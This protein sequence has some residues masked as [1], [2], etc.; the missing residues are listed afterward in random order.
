MSQDRMVFSRGGSRG[1]P[2]IFRSLFTACLVALFL[3]ACSGGDSTGGVSVADRGQE[4]Q[5]APNDDL[6]DSSDHEQ[7]AVDPD[8]A[9]AIDAVSGE[10]Y[11]RE[12]DYPD[13]VTLPLQYIPT[14]G[15]KQLSVRVTLPA[16]DNG[17]PLEGPFPVIVTQSAYN[18]NLLSLMF[19]G[20]PGN[21]LL[22]VSD[23]FVVRRG[24]AQVAV[25]ALGTGAS[26]GVWELLGEDE[27]AGFADAVAWADRQPWSNGKVG[28]AGVSYMAIS[29][30]FAAQHRPDL[31]DAIFASLPMGDAM[32]GTVGIGGMLNAVFMSE[33]MS[34]TH[35]LAT[36]NVQTALLNPEHAGIL[37]RA[38]REH[39]EQL[40]RYH[41]PLLNNALD[42]A[43]EYNYDGEFWRLR[44][45]IENM[46]RIKAPTFL[47]G[48]LHDIFQRDTPMLYEILRR[49]G[50]DTRLVVYEGTHFVNFIKSHVGNE[51]VPPIDYLLLQWFDKYLKGYDTG[52]DK[53]P[54][55]V[56]HIKNYP[57]DSTPEEFQNDSYATATDWPHP[58][59]TP[60][61]WYLRGDNRLTITPPI[62]DEPGHIMKN[63]P[64]PF[65]RAYG[66]NGLLNFELNITD[67]T[68][69]TRSYEQW[70]LGLALP[71]VCF[72]DS[73]LSTQQR[74]VFESEPMSED[75]YLNGP[76]QADIWIE[77]TATEAVVAVQIEEVSEA[78]VL[79]I[80]N[81]QLLASARRVDPERSRYVDGEMIQPYHF[82]TEE[83]NEPLVPGEVVLMQVEIFPT[84]V[85]IRKGNRLR[86][87]VSPSN[88]AQAILNYPRQAMA[89]G[90]ITTVHNSADYPSSVVLPV[91]P[92]S[93]LD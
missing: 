59:M 92:T 56:Q 28:V 3:P 89:E 46:D 34:V 31:V 10:I 8:S 93:V 40:D 81:G 61:R 53:I 63:P 83:V 60:E 4:R 69:C 77:S 66:S 85:I 35:L 22:G 82:F 19:L 11:Y 42:G 18:T 47:F 67:G 79:P 72:W 25:D 1:L 33:W 87:S 36:Q 52:T 23:D 2:D 55:V 5:E 57:T 9:D 15:G 86:V 41:L 75:Y 39:I 68:E 50:V 51:Q 26:E 80:T 24:Y 29:S 21:L 76:I 12:P 62:G 32:R 65:G 17:N 90:G 88:Q 16:D 74:L 44:S 49:N 54:P 64:A 7:P 58:M 20:L 14:A 84:S 70:T 6:P 73:S 71:D 78:K 45:P 43:P 30:L 13:A 27:Q 91:V 37:T 48:A 38:T